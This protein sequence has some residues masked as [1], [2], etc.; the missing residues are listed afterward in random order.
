M[1][2]AGIGAEDGR[3]EPRGGETVAVGV[4]CFHKIRDLRH[5]GVF[6]FVRTGIPPRFGYRVSEV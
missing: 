2:K 5:V 6:H 1:L 3:M 4:D